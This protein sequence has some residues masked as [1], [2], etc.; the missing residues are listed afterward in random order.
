MK[1]LRNVLVVVGVLVCSSLQ[2]QTEVEKETQK[3]RNIGFEGMMAIAINPLNGV[4]AFNVGGPVA[5]ITFSKNLSAGVGAFPSL[6]LSRDKFEPKLGWGLRADYKKW[7][8][9]APFYHFNNPDRWVWTAGTGY[10]F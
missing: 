4:A 2:A 10:K 6:Y 1:Y 3:K 8:V 7:V 5:R 9:I